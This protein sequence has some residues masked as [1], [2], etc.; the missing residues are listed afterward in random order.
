MRKVG[1]TIFDLTIPLYADDLVGVLSDPDVD[2]KTSVLAG[3]TIFGVGGGKYGGKTIL[4]PGSEEFRVMKDMTVTQPRFDTEV[5]LPEYDVNSNGQ[6]VKVLDEEGKE[7][8]KFLTTSQT[9]MYNS[10]LR[11]TYSS[12]VN[13]IEEDFRDSLSDDEKKELA[14]FL[15]KKSKDITNW[16][17]FASK[18]PSKG[19]D[20][21][22]MIDAEKERIK[23]ILSDGD[24]PYS[25]VFD[26]MSKSDNILTPKAIDPQ[27]NE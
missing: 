24:S 22:E 12:F 2:L 7:K 6:I 4:R 25:F 13:S 8:K 27:E 5:K 14:D 18:I 15:L 11:N 20:I 9:K 16:E 19:S 21:K 23:G 3:S 17:Y 1:E 10:M 26:A